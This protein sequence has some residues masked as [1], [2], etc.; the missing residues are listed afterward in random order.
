MTISAARFSNFYEVRTYAT[1]TSFITLTDSVVSLKWLGS[2]LSESRSGNLNHG[3]LCM[4]LTA[5]IS[6]IGR[7]YPLV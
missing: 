5:Y 1:S 2:T 6:W 7:K 4:V 3:K